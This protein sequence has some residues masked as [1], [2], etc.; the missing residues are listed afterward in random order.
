MTG[1]GG[2]GGGPKTHHEPQG[3]GGGWWAYAGPYTPTSN[4]KPEPFFPRPLSRHASLRAC[5]WR[6]RRQSSRSGVAYSKNVRV[7]VFFLLLLFASSTFLFL[8]T[9]QTGKRSEERKEESEDKLL[10]RLRAKIRRNTVYTKI[11]PN[12]QYMY[13]VYSV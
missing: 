10:R 11:V 13:M 1:G 8:L 12:I 2:G 3:E 5:C 7:E 9:P 4:S 6:A